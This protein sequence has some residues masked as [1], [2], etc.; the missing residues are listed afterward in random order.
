MKKTLFMA[1]S[2]YAKAF[3]TI[4]RTGLWLKLL[5][6]GINGRFLKIVQDMYE[7]SKSCVMLKNKKSNAFVSERGVKQG[8]ILSPLLFAFYINDL[9]K[10][11]KSEGVQPLSGIKST[12]DE[13]MTLDGIDFL[14]EILTLFYADDTIIFSDSA[15]GLQFA[16]EELENYCDIWKLIVNEGKTKILCITPGRQDIDNFYRNNK[17][18][19]IV[20]EYT[21]LGLHFSKK[22]FNQSLH[23]WSKKSSLKSL[24]LHFDKMQTK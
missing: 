16:L 23:K 22:W 18:L 12:V 8:E 24:C 9:E 7:K 14:L 1:F 2:D 13:V 17:A 15:L 19:E 20:L 4:W 6:M 10:H 21:Y 5:N 11:F 3:D